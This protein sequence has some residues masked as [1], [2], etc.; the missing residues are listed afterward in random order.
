MHH[1][2]VAIEVHH[3]PDVQRAGEELEFRAGFVNPAPVVSQGLGM[4]LPDLADVWSE[5]PDSNWAG[6][7]RTCI[8]PLRA[9]AF[10]QGSRGSRLFFR[11]NGFM[12][13]SRSLEG[14]GCGLSVTHSCCAHPLVG[15]G[16]EPATIQRLAD[17]S[18][19]ELPHRKCSSLP[20]RRRRPGCCGAGSIC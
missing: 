2:E 3:H 12:E 5:R 17:C 6:L 13:I 10:H 18:P 15:A 8:P 20:H 9:F 16:V 7:W 11:V 19:V 1:G 4:A 14:A